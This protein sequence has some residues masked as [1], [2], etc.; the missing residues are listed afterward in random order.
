MEENGMCIY[1]ALNGR[2]WLYSHSPSFIAVRIDGQSYRVHGNNINNSS[3]RGE[4]RVKY[5]FY[6]LVRRQDSGL[7]CIVRALPRFH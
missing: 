5:K 3:Y 4:N 2:L 7:F 1:G 6:E